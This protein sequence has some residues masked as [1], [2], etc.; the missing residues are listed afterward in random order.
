ME[1]P[2]V[3]L[4]LA[5]GAT[6]QQLQ[7][8]FLEQSGAVLSQAQCGNGV[9]GSLSATHQTLSALLNEPET[10]GPLGPAA[11]GEQAVVYPPQMSADER[12][13]A[14]CWPAGGGALYQPPGEML[15]GG[16]TSVEELY[17]SRS[18]TWPVPP[19]NMTPS[20]RPMLQE[21]AETD[22]CGATDSTA[23]MPAAAEMPAY[24]TSVALVGAMPVL[25]APNGR[26]HASP[27]QQQQ[28]QQAPLLLL[29]N[30]NGSD[31]T[32]AHSFSAYTPQS[33]S[34]LVALQQQQQQLSAQS[35]P[36]HASPQQQ[37]FLQQQQQPYLLASPAGL[38]QS[39]RETRAL[40]LSAANVAGVPTRSSPTSAGSG[41][42][43]C[44]RVA[45]ARQCARRPTLIARQRA[46]LAGGAER[47]W[48]PPRRTCARSSWRVS[49][50]APLEWSVASVET[51]YTQ[52]LDLIGPLAAGSVACGAARHGTH[53]AQWQCVVSLT[54]V[55]VS[56]VCCASFHAITRLQSYIVLD[57]SAIDAMPCLLRHA[58]PRYLGHVD[59]C[60]YAPPTHC[61]PLPLARPLHSTP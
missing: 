43:Q 25:Y 54:S 7:Q 47:K 15:N 3:Q 49:E 17:R 32:H 21:L 58:A 37:L 41:A 29:G 39:L 51:R 23:E 1:T 2:P 4:L 59:S 53:E 13:L 14:P 46:R 18:N 24:L 50:S 48:A 60:F 30:G 45:C 22:E 34:N 9:G 38:S 6:Q 55:S 20:S 16:V 56:E 52:R 28:Q 12:L 5:S 19:P 44:A 42:R 61:V 31:R 57:H 11:G 8:L 33:Q 36:Q 10:E 27:E 35:T 40:S 26:P